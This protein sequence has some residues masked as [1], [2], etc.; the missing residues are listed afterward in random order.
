MTEEDTCHGHL[1]RGQKGKEK[2]PVEMEESQKKK[3][4][5]HF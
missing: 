5:L 1:T 2:H 3:K 4:S